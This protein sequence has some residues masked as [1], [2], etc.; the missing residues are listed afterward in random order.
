MKR[1]RLVF[2]DRKG[3]FQRVLF[4]HCIEEEL[5]GIKEYFAMMIEQETGHPVFCESISEQPEVDT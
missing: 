1:F 5:Q 2:K 3:H 4:A